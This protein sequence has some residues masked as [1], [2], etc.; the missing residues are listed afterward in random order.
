MILIDAYNV[1]HVTGVLP[2]DLAGLDVPELA[3]LMTHSRFGQNECLLICDGVS[4][5]NKGNFLASSEPTGHPGVRTVYAGAGRDADSLI[6]S[7]IAR[8][9]APRSIVVVSSDG[10]LKRAARKRRCTWISSE[11]FLADLSARA[12]AAARRPGGERRHGAD[13]GPMASQTPLGAS[14]VRGWLAHFGID[15][16]IAGPSAEA[17]SDA[18]GLPESL[19]AK[20]RALGP[21]VGGA[22]QS[23]AHG[24]ERRVKAARRREDSAARGGQPL[25][26][27]PDVEKEK[28]DPFVD[29]IAIEAIE[30]W[31]AELSASDTDLRT[32]LR[33]TG[34][35][36]T[37]R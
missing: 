5:T 3:E 13:K 23:R 21:K 28:A 20:L 8:S 11:R 6:E 24:H 15:P 34:R 37:G 4:P 30:R 32:W 10:R 22:D 16:G 25:G 2:P 35:D 19:L 12:I 17:L 29:P 36:R 31:A 26:P 9:S 33:D 18:A 1:L 14:A 7:L 27:R